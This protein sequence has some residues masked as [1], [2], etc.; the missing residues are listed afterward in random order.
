MLVPSGIISLVPETD[1]APET[2]GLE[3][4]FH[5]GKVS[6]GECRCRRNWCVYCTVITKQCN[7]WI[8]MSG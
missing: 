3:D 1:K 5:F 7:C 8:V 4:E 2:K 6:L